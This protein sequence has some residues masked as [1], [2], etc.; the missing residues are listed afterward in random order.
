[1]EVKHGALEKKRWLFE[2]NRKSYN[3]SDM[4]CEAI[5]SKKQQGVD[6]HVGHKGLFIDRM[7]KTSFMR[8]YS[9]VLRKEDENVI[10]KALKFE[11][12][13]SRG[14]P[15]QICKKQI[16]NEIKKSELVKE[17]ACNRTKW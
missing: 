14:R 11:E 13:G 5:R 16:E 10:V 15:K 7:A 1:M 3:S 17:D 9:H 8:W 12:R 2:Q 4:W 6:G